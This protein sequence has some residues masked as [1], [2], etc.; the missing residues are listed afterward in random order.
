[1]F[2]DKYMNVANKARKLYN[3]I[4]LLPSRKHNSFFFLAD[5]AERH[6][7]NQ[8]KPSG[9]FISSRY[10][11]AKDPTVLPPYKEYS[12]PVFLSP[13]PGKGK[14]RYIS[15][16]VSQILPKEVFLEAQYILA[17]NAKGL[18]S[19]NRVIYKNAAEKAWSE[20][21]N[22]FERNYPQ[23]KWEKSGFDKFDYF[24]AV[25]EA[26]KWVKEN[27]ESMLGKRK[28]NIDLM[29]GWRSLVKSEAAVDISRRALMRNP[30]KRRLL[31]D[32]NQI[33]KGEKLRFKDNE[34]KS[35]TISFGINYVENPQAV[36]K[37]TYRVIQPGGKLVLVGSPNL[38]FT[39]IEKKTFDPMHVTNLLENS[40]FKDIQ[41]IPKHFAYPSS[42][43][44]GNMDVDIRT[45]Y[46]IS[47]T[48]PKSSH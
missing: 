10:K 2:F 45:V 20:M 13:L 7:E 38:G 31:F 25:P 16:F 1:M 5:L 15:P 39:D 21:A 44:I 9:R 43:P 26:E 29:G 46:I 18:R 24:N 34:F 42:D 28:K 32:M 17:Q 11:K 33:S 23:S 27:L 14:R 30:A 41:L 40:G 8:N 22:L 35:A 3:R 37:E 6:T 4:N 47:A 12:Y 19:K 36:M 48:K